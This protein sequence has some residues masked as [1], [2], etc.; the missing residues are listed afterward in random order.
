ML[1]FPAEA[2]SLAVGGAVLSQNRRLALIPGGDSL[3]WNYNMMKIG[4]SFACIFC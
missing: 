3:K 2:A 4:I 1:F